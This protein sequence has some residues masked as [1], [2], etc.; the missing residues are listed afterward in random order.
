MS[1][2]VHH[3]RLTNTRRE[4]V[5]AFQVSCETCQQEVQTA[6]DRLTSAS[7]DV[8]MLKITLDVVRNENHALEA[9]NTAL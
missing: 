6:E 8:S 3:S 5:V 4:E 2:D 1:L 9:E 7:R